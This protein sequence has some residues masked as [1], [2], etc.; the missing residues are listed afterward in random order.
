M[1]VYFTLTV[2]PS[3]QF[4][5]QSFYQLQYIHKVWSRCMP[6][7]V[8]WKASDSQR[9]DQWYGWGRWLYLMGNPRAQY[10]VLACLTGLLVCDP[11]DVHI[12]GSLVI[13]MRGQSVCLEIADDTK[14]GGLFDTPRWLWC[15]SEEFSTGWRNGQRRNSLVKQRKMQNLSELEL[16]SLKRKGMWL[17]RG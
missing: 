12:T 2:G 14:L 16:F 1:Y 7:D 3:E 17:G 15:L 6:S 5:A 13:Q 11:D 8:D 9:C 10:W 4:E